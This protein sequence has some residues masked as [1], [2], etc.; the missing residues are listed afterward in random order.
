LPLSGGAISGDLEVQGSTT[1]RGLVTNEYLTANMAATFNAG[2]NVFRA[3]YVNGDLMVAANSVTINRA[4]GMSSG[5]TMNAPTAVIS[6]LTVNGDIVLG[7]TTTDNMQKILATST[8]NGNNYEICGSGYIISILLMKL[9]AT[10]YNSSQN[11]RKFA[12]NLNHYLE[13]IR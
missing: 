8:I 4:P 11:R 2:A 13:T 1:L 12:R 6:V 5:L 10:K 7:L 3:L 9:V